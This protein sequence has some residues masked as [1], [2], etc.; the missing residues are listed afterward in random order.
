VS[1]IASDAAPSDRIP[2]RTQESKT[3]RSFFITE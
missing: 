3:A 2:I 1:R